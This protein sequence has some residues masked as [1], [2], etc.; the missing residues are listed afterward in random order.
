MADNTEFRHQIIQGWS[1]ALDAV[2]KAGGPSVAVPVTDMAI[3]LD[4]ALEDQIEQDV[5]A[6]YDRQVGLWGEQDLPDGTGPYERLPGHPDSSMAHMARTVR[7]A[8]Q[9]AEAKGKK[10]WSLVLME[11]VFEALAEG[12]APKRR[13]ELVQCMAVIKMWIRSKDHR[14]VE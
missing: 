3:I 10:T 12:A 13:I 4:A 7:A 2:R 9:E 14:S 6:E 11:E 5:R 8:C 1:D